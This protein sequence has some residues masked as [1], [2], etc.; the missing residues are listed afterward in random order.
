MA[1]YASNIF[2]YLKVIYGNIL[3]DFCHLLNLY[4]K[5]SKINAA[6]DYENIREA[7]SADPRIGPAWLNVT[8]GNYCGA[9]GY[10]FPKDMSAFIKFGQELVQELAG[11]NKIDKDLTAVLERG[12]NVLTAAVNYNEAILNWQGLTI[13]D[14]S[15]HDKDIITSKRR[16]IR[17]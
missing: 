6:V 12:I 13:Q 11:K 15:R 4:F 9:G 16:A 8:H 10:C 1:K 5:N 2:G 14:V 17:T 3:A 7:I